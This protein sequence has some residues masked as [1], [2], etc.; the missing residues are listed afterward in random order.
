MTRRTLFIGLGFVIA[1]I[2]VLGATLGYRLS[3]GAHLFNSVQPVDRTTPVAIATANL[4]GSGP[5]SVVSAMTVP[6]LSRD[7]PADQVLAAKVVYRSTEG[8]TSGPTEVSGMVF[9]PKKPPPPGGW[10]VFAFA[11][12]STGIDT[13]CAPSLSA[14][15]VGQGAFITG[16]IRAGFAVAFPDYQ[17]LGAPGIHPYLD[18]RTAGFNLIDAV[19]ALRNTFPGISPKWAAYGSSQG[20]GAAWA[21]NEQAATY[22]PELQLVGATAI[23]PSTNPVALLDKAEAGTLTRS[24]GPVFVWLLTAINRLNP[25]LDLN[26]FRRGVAAQHWD[27]I[28]ACS[29]ALLSTRNQAWNDL[30]APDLAPATPEAAQQLRNLLM[31]WVLPQRPLSAPLFVIYGG[32]DPFIDAAWVEEAVAHACALGGTVVWRLEP[33]K[34]HDNLDATDQVHW[35]ADRFEGKPVSSDCR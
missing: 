13:H 28:S 6:G 3:T 9:A 30:T 27:A 5:G 14:D 22:A 12:G 21:A 8:D 23:A 29:G 33:P 17:G 25:A 2:A 34:G 35:L 24:Q 16:W 4:T 7:V 1:F 18:S 11:H 31:P 32:Q 20:G 19:R 15:L 26:N 10:P